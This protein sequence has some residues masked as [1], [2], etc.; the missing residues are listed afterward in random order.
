MTQEQ[1]FEQ[2]RTELDCVT[3][4]VALWKEEQAQRACNRLAE[5]VRQQANISANAEHAI[6]L[7]EQAVRE[8]DAL[9]K[10][11]A[12]AFEGLTKIMQGTEDPQQ[13]AS[14][15]VQTCVDA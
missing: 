7:V 4:I 11:Y 5:H 2:Y 9:K 12:A 10:K 1:R 13:V 15:Y 6:L 14:A 8:R 3:E